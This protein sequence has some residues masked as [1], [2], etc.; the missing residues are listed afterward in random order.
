MLERRD[1]ARRTNRNRF[2]P[3]INYEVSVEMHFKKLVVDREADKS[4]TSLLRSIRGG[5]CNVGCHN[6]NAFIEKIRTLLHG[7]ESFTI[8]TTWQGD[9]TSEM[10]EI[11]YS[12]SF[13]NLQGI[14]NTAKFCSLVLSSAIKCTFVNTGKCLENT[15]NSE[16]NVALQFRM[17]ELAK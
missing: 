9:S 17:L 3:E 8:L 10:A 14:I 13:N 2:S 16:N 5:L 6:N 15:Y 7:G 11:I 1:G 12:Y 4:I